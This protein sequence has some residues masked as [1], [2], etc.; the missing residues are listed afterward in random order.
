[1]NSTTHERNVSPL[2]L[3]QA[4]V[5]SC[6]QAESL[7][8]PKGA[9]V[10]ESSER[11]S[12]VVEE[13]ATSRITRREALKRA[14]VFGLG[15]AALGQL[16]AGGLPSAAAAAAL[17]PERTGATAKRG[18]TFREGYDRDFTPPNPVANNWADPDYNALFEA[19]V[20]RNPEGQIVPMLADRFSSTPTGW[21][22]HLRQGLKFQ[23]GTPV[24]PAAV[25]EDFDLFRSPKTGQNGPFWT[26]IYDVVAQGPNIVCK[27]HHPFQAFQETVA[28]EYSYIMNPTT[29]KAQGAKYGT[30]ATDGTG[31]FVLSSYVPGQHA[32]AK[33]WNDYPG[34]VVPF[35]A[36]KGK[37]YLDAIEWI[38]IT[39]AT[40]RAPQIQTGLVDAVKNPPPQ[41]VAT[42]KA[43]KNLVVLEFQ[44]LSNFFL[45][46]NLGDTTHGFDDL[47]VRQ[48]I[49]HAID[50]EAIVKAIFLGHAAATY[51]PAMT[52]W[53]WYN[54]AVENYNQFNTGI[55]NSLLDEAGWKMGSSGVRTKHGKPLAF[56]TYN[57]TDTTENQV[58]A[59]IAQMLAKVGVK[60]TVSS[61][62][63]AA[64]YPKLTAKTTSYAL[65]WLWSSPIDVVALFVAF[66]Q[67]KTASISPVDDAFNAW[68]TAATT[69]QLKAAALNYQEHFAKLI[70]L[71][72]I[73]TQNTIWVHNKNVVGWQP[74]QANL[75]PFY[76]DV[77][78]KNA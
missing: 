56:T 46:V 4:L 62:A 59:A 64:F 77:Y 50:R 32:I 14:G 5:L 42:L 44:E 7:Q 28:T 74:N 39:D 29:W 58:M 54:P 69:A 30:E 10:D 19:L 23:S 68:Q 66:Y 37:A 40:Q 45:S 52:R 36:N 17:R 2:D 60:M 13:Y 21:T 71:I 25:V 61:L 22:F 11:V 34:S 76:N 43:D 20:I 16:L 3:T 70:P 24:T 31:P 38:P 72:P 12:D 67:P 41:D 18:G 57:L 48:A 15:A 35:F 78:L 47:R 8:Q 49:S 6:S 53:K 51:G 55:A 73:Y 9:L 65:K 27:T 33:R 63:S 26:P 1:V 75:Y